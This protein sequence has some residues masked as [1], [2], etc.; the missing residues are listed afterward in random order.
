[1]WTRIAS[2]FDVAYINKK[3]ATVLRHADNCTTQANFDTRTP[4]DLT[5]WLNWLDSGKLPYQLDRQSRITLE[6]AMIR[7]VRSLL[8]RALARDSQKT[9]IACA[10]FLVQR[11][12]VPSIERA[13]YWALIKT[14]TVYPKIA[15]ELTRG[16]RWTERWWALEKH[17]TI[18]L[19]AINPYDALKI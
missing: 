13:R 9:V 11:S 12:L 16:R 5:I 18:K 15:N 19:P 14:L 10:K 1:M 17:L 7:M 2:N 4:D 8:Y 6:A 3:V